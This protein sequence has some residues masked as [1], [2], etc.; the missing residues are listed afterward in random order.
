[1]TDSLASRV[2]RVLAGFDEANRRLV[3]RLESASEA[4]AMKAPAPDQWSA[5]Q[6]G[7]HIA[8]FNTLLAGLV[9][10]ALPGARPAPA[11]F[12]QR[13][14]A[15]IQTTLM[16]PVAAP[17]V[18]HPPEDT[19]R[20]A[21]LAALGQAAPAVVSAFSGLTDERAALTIT[22]PRVGTITLVQAGDWLVAHTIRH[23]AQMKRAL[24]R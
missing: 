19:S 20:A 10:G 14:W 22:H 18:L 15:D 21:S 1:M 2:E 9:S 23:N 4:E 24:G 16:N 3:A 11:D 6:I 5:A 8:A 17:R 13:E 7:S 12:V